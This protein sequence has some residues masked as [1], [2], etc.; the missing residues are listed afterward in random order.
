MISRDANLQLESR[1]VN[2]PYDIRRS[3]LSCIVPRS[4]HVFQHEG[5]LK[6]SS[7][8]TTIVEQGGEYEVGYE[9]RLEGSSTKSDLETEHVRGKRFGVVLGRALGV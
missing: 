9:R 3:I 6:R 4:I 8:I 5:R 7:C 2:L 1:L